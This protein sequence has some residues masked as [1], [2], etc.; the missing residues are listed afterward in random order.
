MCVNLAKITHYADKSNVNEIL[1]K[2]PQMINT[3]IYIA[4]ARVIYT[5]SLN[6]NE[7]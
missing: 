5:N 3:N 2:M 1:I 4:L 6:Y 7:S